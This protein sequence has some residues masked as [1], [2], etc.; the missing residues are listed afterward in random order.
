MKALLSILIFLLIPLKAFA[1]VG[2]EVDLDFGYDEQLYGTSHENS[3][4]TRTYSGGFSTYLFNLTA[5][6]LDAS[7]TYE[8]NTQNDRFT[9]ATG[10]DLTSDCN[11]V[12]TDVYSVGI[13]QMLAGRNA[14]IQP[15]I[16]AGY[17][18]EFVTY[19]RVV[20]VQDTTTQIYSV[21]DLGTTKQRT[22]SMY[23]SFIL[24]FKIT[25]RLSIKGSVKTLFP[26]FNYNEA[27]SNLKYLAGLSWIF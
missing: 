19:G 14:F 10:F 11:T 2:F 12:K 8:V 1:V 15:A 6:E 25:E 7:R 20:T 23:A 22:D 9:V 27:K 4:V 21:K 26:A 18:K 13:K 24:Q 5:I 3:I 16:S 17:A